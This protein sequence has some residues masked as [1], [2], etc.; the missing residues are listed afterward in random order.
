LELFSNLLAIAINLWVGGQILRRAR[1]SDSRPE[2]LLGWALVFDGLEWLFW[3]LA[4]YT[5]LDGTP[6]GL[7]LSVMCRVGIAIASGFLLAFTWAVFHPGNRWV[8]VPMACV[9]AAIW[10]GIAASLTV[11]DWHG[12]RTDLVWV[13][14][15][16]GGVLLTYG[17][18]FLA[19]ATY[20]RRAR[21]RLALDLGDPLV[22]NRVLLWSA[23]GGAMVLSQTAYLYAMT[24]AEASEHYP[25]VF[26]T[27]ISALTI[28]A[29][30]A[31]WLAFFPPER[32]RRWVISAQPARD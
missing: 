5:P 12:Y 16:S 18:T 7:A 8:R 24:L 23:Y 9:L 3:L 32:Y 6:V 15:E 26:D 28:V 31:I 22:T 10:L 29:C 13:W 1:R 2:R 19:S 30:V 21:R 11:S 14:L 17:W 25:L 4:V 27:A 20:Y